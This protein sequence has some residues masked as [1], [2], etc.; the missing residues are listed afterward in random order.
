MK[1]IVESNKLIAEFMGWKENKDMEVKSI[2]G[3]ITYYFQKNDEACIPEAMCYHSLWNWLMEVVEK[4]ESLPDEENNGKFFFEIYQDS[5]SIFSNGN[6]LNE[7]IEVRGQGSRIK[8]VYQ[9]VIKFIQLYNK[10]N[11]SLS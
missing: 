3:G 7:L 11:E 6:Y 8:N 1:N 9:A 2:S 10:A 5:V 4:I